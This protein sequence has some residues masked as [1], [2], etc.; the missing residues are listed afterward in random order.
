MDETGEGSRDF[1]KNIFRETE[2]KKKKSDIQGEATEEWRTGKQSGL[3]T[4][5]EYHQSSSI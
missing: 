5:M 1:E 4:K 3:L 2:G